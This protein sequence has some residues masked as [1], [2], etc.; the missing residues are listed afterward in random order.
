MLL[1][2]T[3]GC[4][5]AVAAVPP[6]ERAEVEGF[7]VVRVV[8]NGWWVPY[9]NIVV[10]RVEDN[11][12]AYLTGPG[13]NSVDNPGTF[14]GWLDPGTYRF[15]RFTAFAEYGVMQR[16]RELYL[17]RLGLPTFTVVAGELV[18][19]GTWLQQPVGDSAA[20]VLLND[21]RAFGEGRRHKELDEAAAAFPGPPARWEGP[22]NWNRS[23]S[24]N[25]L[26]EATK[27]ALVVMKPPRFDAEGNA[28]FASLLGQIL[29]RTPRGEW[30]NLDT[31]TLDTLSSL[32]I[33]GS[34]IAASTEQHR[35]LFSSDGG[36]TWDKAV[37]PVEP[38]VTAI[39]RLPNGD[40]VAA[41]EATSNSATQVLR[42]PDLLGLSP[43]PWVTLDSGRTPR[44]ERRQT[45]M[46][47]PV[48]G[49]LIVWTAPRSLHV[50]DVA[51]D[52]WT[53]SKAAAPLGE[54]YVNGS[55]GLVYSAAPTDADGVATGIRLADGI[56]SADGGTSWRST[57][58]F[59]HNGVGFRDR[60]NGISVHVGPRRI[61]TIET[62]NDGGE[63]WTRLEKDIPGSCNTAYYLP[64]T[65]DLVC[66]TPNGYILSTRT[67]RVWARERAGL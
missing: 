50:Y 23:P 46:A 57:G 44:H 67:G 5:V 55:A 26:V 59:L 10:E 43:K 52:R 6:S 32:W 65:D 38:N 51:D 39:E 17:E 8:Q 54:L 64:P 14:A 66:I 61:T 41:T 60:L 47:V 29:R 42:G 37:V 24:T 62:T 30:Q 19:L 12:D 15:L 45:A 13:I 7:A 34:S 40:F 20:F 22:A 3:I 53:S 58:L 11:R 63:N 48:E 4:G 31:G 56:I 18:D 28:Y 25:E 9:G 21:A 33:D 36:K 1:A 27:R 49:R 35:L 16:H 2:A